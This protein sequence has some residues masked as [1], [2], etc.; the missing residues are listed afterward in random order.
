[1]KKFCALALVILLV[2]PVLAQDADSARSVDFGARAGMTFNPDQVHLGAH[3]DLGF[4]LDS[5]RF[6]PNFEIG[7]G[8]DL[9]VM[10]LAGDLIYD[11]E[12]KPFSLGAE[13]ALIHTE[14]DV[15]LPPGVDLDGDDSTDDLGLSVLG[16][17]RL[18]LSNGKILTLEA[19]VGVV[20]APDFKATVMYNLF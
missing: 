1:M 20:D 16:N 9:T 4:V 5:I 14:L 8:E 12:D 3:A 11:L 17:Y 13:L 15:E 2:T 18:A 7:F 6:V 10:S 19:K